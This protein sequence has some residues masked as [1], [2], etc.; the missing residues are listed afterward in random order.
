[1]IGFKAIVL[2]EYGL[3]ARDQVRV[4]VLENIGGD[5]QRALMPD[6]TWQES[7]PLAPGEEPRSIRETGIVMPTAAVEAI[8]QAIRKWQGQGSDDATEIRVLREWLAVEQH[9]VDGAL[10]K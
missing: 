6:G 9:R 1:M 10:A 2:D 4:V 8:Q 5:H 3:F 7:G